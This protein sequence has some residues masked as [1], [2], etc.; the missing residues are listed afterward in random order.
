MELL[1]EIYKEIE[2]I[3]KTITLKLKIIINKWI[4]NTRKF[5][6]LSSFF[7]IVEVKSLNLTLLVK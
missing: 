6:W 3:E 7:F 4:N 1:Y 2:E 5:E